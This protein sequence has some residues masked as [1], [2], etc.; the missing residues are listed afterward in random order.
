MPQ[1]KAT[2]P[3]DGEPSI[4]EIVAELAAG[5]FIELHDDGR[6]ELRHPGKFIGDHTMQHHL[7]RHGWL[8]ST[9][10]CGGY[11]LST[12]GHRAYMRS[13]D[14]LGNGELVPPLPRGVRE[15]GK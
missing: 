10:N 14:E 5:A 2:C 9:A 6:Y 3:I 7:I 1:L 11:V 8:D 15:N 12:D 4:S 13:T